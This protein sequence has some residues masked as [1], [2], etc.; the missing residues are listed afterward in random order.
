MGSKERAE[1][2]EVLRSCCHTCN[3]IL[4]ARIRDKLREERGGRGREGEG[5]GEGNVVGIDIP[6][7]A[8]GGVWVVPGGDAM[9]GPVYLYGKLEHEAVRELLRQL[10]DQVPPRWIANHFLQP[11]W[12]LWRGRE[13]VWWEGVEGG[14]V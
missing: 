12:C 10:V 11:W 13:R 2:V 9:M 4:V 7:K 3:L 1:H 14:V 8:D 5:G 6:R